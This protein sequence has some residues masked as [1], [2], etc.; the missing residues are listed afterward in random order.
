MAI[1]F[2]KFPIWL[3]K[4]IIWVVLSI[5]IFIFSGS[6]IYKIWGG[7]DISFRDKI[8]ENT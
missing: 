5:S 1:K 2:Y 3:I 4:F 7:G 6:L 8:Y